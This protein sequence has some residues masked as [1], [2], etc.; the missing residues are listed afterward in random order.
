MP[1]GCDPHAVVGACLFTGC[2]MHHGPSY[3]D[4]NVCKCQPGYCSSDGWVCEMILTSTSITAA[5]TPTAVTGVTVAGETVTETS[6]TVTT[7]DMYYHHHHHHDR[8]V[9]DSDITTTTT[10]AGLYLPFGVSSRGRYFPDFWNPLVD[11]WDWMGQ[12]EQGISAT[13][14]MELFPFNEFWGMVLFVLF[15]FYFYRLFTVV[16]KKWNLPFWRQWHVLPFILMVYQS[17]LYLISDVFN[18]SIEH[19]GIDWHPFWNLTCDAGHPRPRPQWNEK[20]HEG[21]AWWLNGILHLSPVPA[22]LS[23]VI[24]IIQ[25]AKL[26]RVSRSGPLTSDDIRARDRAIFVFMMPL[27]FCLA[28]LA[29]QVRLNQI[30]SGETDCGSELVDYIS[31]V[32]SMFQLAIVLQFTC[33]LSIA[34]LLKPHFPEGW[35]D[36]CDGQGIPWVLP[37]QKSLMSIAWTVFLVG[38]ARYVSLMTLE[39]TT[40]IRTLS[41][42]YP[43]IVDTV[44][45]SAELTF[46]IA[47][48]LSFVSVV[49][50][51]WGIIMPV[52]KMKCGD[53]GRRMLN[54]TPTLMFLGSRLIVFVCAIQHQALV[55][56]SFDPK[57]WRTSPLGNT[58]GC[59][60][61]EGICGVV[62]FMGVD[63]EVSGYR[64]AL[65]HAQ[66]SQYW[67]CIAVAFNCI[68]LHRL[69]KRANK[70]DGRWWCLQSYFPA[71]AAAAAAAAAPAAEAAAARA[72]ATAPAAAGAADPLV[73][74]L[75]DGA[76][77]P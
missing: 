44:Y 50:F 25:W 48:S 9:H 13:Q 60:G 12:P 26:A 38:I 66:L 54:R 28:S 29:A 63:L 8:H 76:G 27:W 46:K 52:L 5:E 21:L 22:C 64:S 34:R 42:G 65:T 70:D 67:L 33:T 3:C 56:A 17:V 45:S 14:I 10:L 11:A 68:A 72:A 15:P 35:Y 39:L 69:C 51:H 20:V 74:P 75:L 1:Y 77:A 19:E 55:P 4:H 71:P 47:H 32:K 18:F 59:K 36:F 41:T 58:L 23:L 16:I 6:T 62:N 49:A 37:G 57:K 40:R 2:F 73:V 24:L 53:G 31:L 61:Q 43:P 7:T 30:I